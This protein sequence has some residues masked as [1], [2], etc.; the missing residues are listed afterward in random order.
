MFFAQNKTRKTFLV[1]GPLRRA[2]VSIIH[3]R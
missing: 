1:A 2:T 3:S